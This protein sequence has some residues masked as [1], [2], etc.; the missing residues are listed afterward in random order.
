[1]DGGPS[2]VD[3]WDLKEGNGP[4]RPIETAARD[5]QISENFPLIA[6]Q[7]KDLAIVRSVTSVEADHERA[8]YYL[9]TGNRPEESVI[10]PT[11]GA[12][13]SNE[14]PASAELPSFVWMNDY[15]EGDP[16]FLGLEHA[17][18]VVNPDNGAKG[19]AVPERFRPRLKQRHALLDDMNREFATRSDAAQIAAEAKVQNRALAMLGPKAVHAFDISQEDEKV[20]TAY[21]DTKFGRGCLQARR[22]VE[23]GVRFV[24]VALDGWDAHVNNFPQVKKLSAVLDPAMGSL[25][26]ELGERGLLEQTLVICMGEFGRTPTVNKANG[27]DHYSRAFSVVLAGGGVAGGRTIGRTNESGAEVAEQP[28]TVP[29]LYASIF[30]AFGFDPAKEYLAPGGRPVR[31]INNGTGIKNLFA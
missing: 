5:I 28:V 7:A 8:T 1:M 20:R 25:I 31:L 16:G 27:R 26:R 22:L 11:L 30:Q 4:F 13:A 3:T 19:V 2:H 17:P 9:H 6:K 18:F 12:I 24:E 15:R 10:F 23:N 21:G 29:D 14:W